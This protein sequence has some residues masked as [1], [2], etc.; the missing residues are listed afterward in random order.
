M[1]ADRFAVFYVQKCLSLSFLGY[2]A[3]YVLLKNK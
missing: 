2:I 1:E 3:R